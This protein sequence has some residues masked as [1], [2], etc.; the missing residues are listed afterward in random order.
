M[1]NGQPD[2]FGRPDRKANPPQLGST[3]AVQLPGEV[4]MIA[5]YLWCRKMGYS[6]LRA[7]WEAFES[8][9]LEL[10]NLRNKGLRP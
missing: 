7:L 10:H 5:R 6:I 3:Q 9:D 8:C 1:V 4:I 2:C